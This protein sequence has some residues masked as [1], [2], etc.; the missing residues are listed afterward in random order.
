MYNSH[1]KLS[2]VAAF[3]MASGFCG[4]ARAGEADLRFE[5]ASV[6]RSDPNRLGGVWRGG[7]GTPSPGRLTAENIPFA[8]LAMHAYDVKYRHQIDWKLPWM[9]T[10]PYDVVAS[11]PAGTTK[12]QFRT[13]L[14]RLLEE[15]FGLVVHRESRQLSGFRLVVAKGG[16][17]LKKSEGTPVPVKTGGTAPESML[18]D[19]IVFKNGVPEFT[20]N[21]PSG[22]LRTAAGNV[23]HGRHDTMKAL[24][25]RL[26]VELQA[27]VIDATGLEGEFDYTLSF[28][29]EAAVLPKG[30]NLVV[31]PGFGMATTEQDGPVSTRPALLTALQEQ[32]GLKLE[33]AKAVPV[34]VLVL[35]K[36]NR[37]PTE[38]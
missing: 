1:A 5:V 10:E 21:S 27:P 7:P 26:L 20:E 29:H 4:Y 33:A 34:E 9:E 15:R 25:E 8:T 11:V 19:G 28:A 18:A 16:A 14:Q 3:A 32:L 38:N 17:K 35:D 12:E 6:K 23:I 30:G 24:V 37:N 2:I 31:G 22:V 13:M 36:A